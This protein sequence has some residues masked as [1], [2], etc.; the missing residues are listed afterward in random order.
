MNHLR[1][2]VYSNLIKAQKELDKAAHKDSNWLDVVETDFDCDSYDEVLISNSKL[3]LDFSPHNGGALFE[4]DFKPLALNMTNTLSRR[5]EPYH[6]KALEKAKAHDT[7]KKNDGIDSIHDVSRAKDAEL[8]ADLSYDWYRR[9]SLLDHFLK[10]GTTVKDFATSKYGEAGDFLGGEYKYDIKK[11][12]KPK[13]ISVE[14]IRDG[15][16]WGASGDIYKLKVAKSVSI[17]PDSGEIEIGYK[18]TNLDTREFEP[19]FGVEFNYSLKDPHLNKVGEAHGL[20]SINVNDQW[21]GVK[22]DF[23]FSKAA[24]FW[25]FPIET[26]SDSEQGLERTYQ[27]LS[28]LFHWKFKLAPR[29]VW[30]V[31]ITKNIKIEE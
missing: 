26:V 4:L 31:K 15:N 1:S 25:Y 13:A 28:L 10:E 20:T 17:K 27:E 19:W 2:A 9:V 14:L 16:Y 12:A 18:I 23:E 22:I 3:E 7:G 8:V 24:D 29:A 30:G 5:R 21:Y 6:E 11:E